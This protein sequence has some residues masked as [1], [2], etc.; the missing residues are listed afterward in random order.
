MGGEACMWTEM[1][2]SITLESRI[3]PRA[4][5]IAE[6]LWSPQE[7]TDDPGDM[8]RRLMN[9]NAYLETLGLDHRSY[10]EKLLLDRVNERYR[11]SLNALLE[12]LSED[13]LFNRMIIYDPPF[14]VNTPLN[15]VVDAAAPESYAA[16]RFE[17]KV[18]AWL[19]SGDDS[20]KEE[21]REQLSQWVLLDES[22]ESAFEE[23]PF[24][25]EVEPHVRAPFSSSGD[26]LAGMLNEPKKGNPSP[27]ELDLLLVEARKAY[28]GYLALRYSR[29]GE[30]DQRI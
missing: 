13:R 6:K 22:L 8:Y 27:E 16:I 29:T 10:R 15:R 25:E 26:G 24:L 9:L 7:L 1:S 2:D 19:E 5:A 21:L 20:L 18:D 28:G 17:Q 3:W 12:M 11:G 23:Y 14:D 4:G 30:T